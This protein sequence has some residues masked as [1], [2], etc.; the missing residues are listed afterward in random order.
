MPAPTRRSASR[1]TWF[2]LFVTLAMLVGT[3]PLA[4]SAAQPPGGRGAQPEMIPRDLVLALINYGAGM[5]G[6]NDL[7]V[8]R[9]PEDIPPELVPP[10]SEI[11]G[12]LTQFENVI[13]VLGVPEAPDSAIGVMESRLL[14][15]GWTRPTPAAPRPVP[16][17]FVAADFPG[18]A[19]GGM[20]NVVCR[21]DEF[22]TL[23]SMYRNSGGSLLKVTFNRG[24][25]YSACRQRT[26]TTTYRSPYEEAPV[27][28]LRAPTGAM[29]TGGGGMSTSGSNDFTMSARLSTRL[30][31]AEV[32]A[33]YDTQ[34]RAAGWSQRGDGSVEF[35]A[36]RTYQKKDE[37][38]RTWSATL[39]AIKVPD[40]LEQ[41]VAL[42]L[43]RR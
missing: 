6:G 26:E 21:G 17:G 27:P 39:S 42:H 2:P 43:S 14:A 15:A 24:G 29:M 19:M 20:P 34:M 12:S 25:R 18:G 13:V 5:G 38:E 11:V 8:G 22:V 10:K 36:A 37:K 32:V 1:F 4:L 30:K 33:H 31:P 7:L 3:A 28:V 9:A 16:R 40:G 41:D 35:L 23:T